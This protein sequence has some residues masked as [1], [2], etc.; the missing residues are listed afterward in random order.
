MIGT[1]DYIS[2]ERLLRF[3]GSLF[4]ALFNVNFSTIGKVLLWMLFA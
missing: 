1:K 4:P 2:D 3:V